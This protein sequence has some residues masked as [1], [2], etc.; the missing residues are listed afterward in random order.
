MSYGITTAVKKI[1]AILKRKKIIQGSSSAGKTIAILIILID[2]AIKKPMLEISV[3][4]ESI[5]HL[6]KGAL[7]DFIKIMK[8]TGRWIDKNYNATD[9]IYRFS[10]GSYIEFFSPESV[11]GSRRNI[12][13]VNECNNITYAD[14]H[15]LAIRTS[16]EIYLD[17]NPSSEFWAH[18]EVMNEPN[19]ELIQLNY[20][21]NESRPS[22]VDEEFGIAIEKAKKEKEQGLPITSYW[23]NWVKVY[24]YG[25][26]G[27]LQG[28]IFN[29]WRQVD[30]VPISAK[31]VARGKDFGFTN[32]PTT[33]TGV[34]Q[35]GNK[36][37][38]DEEIYETGLTNSDILLKYVELGISKKDSIVADSAEP[39]SIEDI[40]RA[41]YNIE[42]AQKGG[43]SIIKSI[44]TLQ[45]FEI[46]ITKRSLNIIK[47][48]RNYKWKV[49]KAGK[50]L[51]E[52]VDHNNHAIDGVRYVA[53]N[54][55]NKPS[56][57]RMRPMGF[58][59]ER[60]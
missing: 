55:I 17:F 27:N 48:F 20:L 6:K 51:N 54:K 3:I 29:N 58:S 44:D 7:K 9:R 11:L 22:N 19:A 59:V 50:A 4:S 30:D 24:V 56:T 57:K 32:D 41:G 31:L 39:K 43:D 13:Y 49:D 47:E 33:L 26:I 37:Y 25:E 52:P 28:V 40:K 2:K 38:L 36:L 60:K 42:A 21:D 35:E 10:N 12:L 16:D 23:Q 8:S 5:P 14:Y 45:Q 18:T 1:L 46:L 15:Q 53:L 34:Y